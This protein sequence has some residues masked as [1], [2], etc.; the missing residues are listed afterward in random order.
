M[1]NIEIFKAPKNLKRKYISFQRFLLNAFN[2]PIVHS[3]DE[4]LLSLVFPRQIGD[5][6]WES[7][8]V[9]VKDSKQSTTLLSFGRGPTTYV[10]DLRSP[11]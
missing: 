1:H 10:G 9:N 2:I 7:V 3:C 4:G 8:F 11:W 5:V 6:G